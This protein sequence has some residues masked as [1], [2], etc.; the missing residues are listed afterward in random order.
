MTVKNL[1]HLTLDEI[2]DCFLLAFENYFVPLPTDREYFKTRWQAAGVDLNY[3]YGMFDK[4]QLVGFILNA[5]DHRLGYKTAFNTGTG[6]V[7]SYRGQGIT[8]S[9]YRSA[10]PDLQNKGVEVST[11][12]VITQNIAAIKAYQSVGFTIQKHFKCFKG[13]LQIPETEDWSLIEIPISQADWSR[14]P[15]QHLYSWDNQ[16]QT[17]VDG[18][19]QMYHVYY[20]GKPESYF[21]LDERQQYLAQ[22]DLFT[23]HNQA[24]DRLFAALQT[25]SPEITVNNIA[26]ELDDK[27]TCLQRVGLINHID[28]YEMGLTL[29]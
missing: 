27:I 26:K 19:Y 18:P 3:S 5:V 9:I 14:L 12:E 15:R 24:W 8:K 28:Q 16:P 29:H 22:F 4:G 23:T 13:K 20:Q 2:L 11:L 6:V 17:L 10:L 25:R 1:S 21:I 7:P